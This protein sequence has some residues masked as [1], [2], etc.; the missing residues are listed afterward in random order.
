MNILDG[1]LCDEISSKELYMDILSFIESFH[2]RKGEFEGN[3][4]VIKKMDEINFL[5]Y[6]E[7]IYPDGHR[8]ISGCISMYKQPLLNAINEFVEK[9]RIFWD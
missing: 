7:D 8:E 2:I 1:F 6:P 3:R 4:Y 9:K 5:I